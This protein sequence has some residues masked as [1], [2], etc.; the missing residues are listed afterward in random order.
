MGGTRVYFYEPL[1]GEYKY[2]GVADACQI[3]GVPL[4]PAFAT[5]I[6][7]P[8]EVA[9]KVRVFN[10]EKEQWGYAEIPIPPPPPIIDTPAPP[11]MTAEIMK[12]R[13]RARY[14]AL[15]DPLFFKWQ[16][17]VK[18]ATKEAWLE[19]RNEVTAMVI[20]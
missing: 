17:G 7:P 14:Q 18:G 6:A 1:S 16:A 15:S 2:P 20:K 12:A 3:T 13:K 4:M 5:T 9:G 11:P 8:G 19:K 10:S